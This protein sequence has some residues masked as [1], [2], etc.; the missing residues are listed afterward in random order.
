M[1]GNNAVDDVY[2]RA[3]E[4]IQSSLHQPKKERQ[5]S[6]K[7][8]VSRL[9]AIELEMLANS[10]RQ[11]A[12]RRKQLSTYVKLGLFPDADTLRDPHVFL[13]FLN[14]RD[15]GPIAPPEQY[16][17]ALRNPAAVAERMRRRSPEQWKLVE[18]IAQQL[19]RY[20][21]RSADYRFN[22]DDLDFASVE[23]Q[24]VPLLIRPSADRNAVVPPH[25][26]AQATTFVR[27]LFATVEKY[28]KSQPE[29]EP[30]LGPEPESEPESTKRVNPASPVSRV[31]AASPVCSLLISACD[32]CGC[33]MLFVSHRLE[34]FL[35]KL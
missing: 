6:Y 7:G 20:K 10:M 24:L 28:G 25:E 22:N 30:E 33:V 26:L 35:L 13:T 15:T 18:D 8:A 11:E 32:I 17:L 29:P 23:A 1:G 27:T 16:K 31:G 12:Y 14:M 34:G 9:E 2:G 5:S 3:A 19:K 4:T 21:T